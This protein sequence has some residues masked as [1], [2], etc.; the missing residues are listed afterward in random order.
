MNTQ[1]MDILLHLIEHGSIT[2]WEA[3]QKYRVTRLAEY[4]RILREEGKDIIST[5]KEHKGKRFVEYS[6]E[7]A[8]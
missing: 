4:V 5:W 3:I 6:L 7:V 2:S 8:A 1:R